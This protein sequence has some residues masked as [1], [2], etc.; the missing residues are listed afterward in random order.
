MA[1]AEHRRDKA[2]AYLSKGESFVVVTIYHGKEPGAGRVDSR[3]PAAAYD[4]F[5]NTFG[6][7][8]NP[9]LIGSVI[10][11]VAPLAGLRGGAEGDN[12]TAGVEFAI[13]LGARSMTGKIGIDCATGTIYLGAMDIRPGLRP[14]KMCG[15]WLSLEADRP[16]IC[17]YPTS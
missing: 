17:A 2:I 3:T 10:G 15:G 13:R 11:P 6:A 7:V 9:V 4:N 1:V 16:K 12:S 14:R 8:E 5:I